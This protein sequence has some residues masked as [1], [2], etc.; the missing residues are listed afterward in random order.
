M[1]MKK[2]KLM[3]GDAHGNGTKH[4]CGD[5][6]DGKH[7]SPSR[8]AERSAEPGARRAHR[9]GGGTLPRCGRE[10]RVW[11]ALVTWGFLEIRAIN[12]DP[13]S[14]RRK[15]QNGPFHPAKLKTKHDYLPSTTPKFNR[16]R[17]FKM[18]FSFP[19]LSYIEFLLCVNYSWA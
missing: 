8:R 7:S 9:R 16:H 15:N 12:S 2:V 17:W 19:S 18:W 4:R 6:T 10:K 11:I 13:E 3:R 5:R 1:Q 14:E